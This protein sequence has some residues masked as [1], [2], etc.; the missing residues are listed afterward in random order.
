MGWATGLE[1]W[2]AKLLYQPDLS[3]PLGATAWWLR[4]WGA[5]VPGY[6]ALAGLLVLFWPKLWQRRPLLYQACAVLA[7]T[8]LLGAGLINQVVVQE[9]ADRHR[10]RETLLVGLA[11]HQLPAELVGNSMPSGHAGIAFA[12]A[13]PFFVWRRRRPQWARLALWGGLAVGAMVG[14][15]R[16]VLGAHYLSD[17]FIAAAISLATASFLAAGM[18]RLQRIHPVWLV[19]GLIVASAA[20]LLGNHFRLTLSANLGTPLPTINL[21]CVVNAI[22]A[23]KPAEGHQLQVQ[24]EGYGAPVS[25]LRLVATSTSVVL[26]QGLGFFHSISCTALLKVEDSRE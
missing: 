3:T 15:G 19:G 26:G 25:N 2:L 13:A 11:G 8:A 20:V 9:L 24:L 10:P 6:L 18:A 22:P 1:Y 16:I 7:F 12:L 5:A 21:P 17:V 23:T 4:Q 14:L